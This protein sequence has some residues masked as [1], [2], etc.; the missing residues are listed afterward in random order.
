ME[1]FRYSEVCMW[2]EGK[3]L[4]KG[5]DFDILDVSTDSRSINRGSL[6]I[7]LK[8]DKFDGHNFI[9]DAV[10]KGA[11]SYITA[12]DKYFR[13]DFPSILVQDTLWAYQRIAQRYLEKISVPVVAITG[14][15]GKTTTKDMIH[16]LLSVKYNVVATEKNY[17]NEIGVP[18]T[19]LRLN[20]N[21]HV[22]VLELAMRGKG[23][24][25]ELSKIVR[26]DVVVITNIGES[27]YEL[28]GSYKAIAEAKCEIFHGAKDGGVS[29]LNADDKWFSFCVKKSCGTVYSY[30]IERKANI[31]LLNRKNRGFLG[32]DLD[33]RYKVADK[34]GEISFFLPLLGE[35]NI[36]NALASLGVGI[37]WGLTHD[38]IVEGFS[39]LSLTGMRMEVKESSGGWVV[40]ND[41]Y[42]ASPT[43]MKK[44][45]E[46]LRGLEVKGKRG[47]VLG[48][49]LELGD[50]ALHS[51][52]EI[53]KLVSK[54]GFD[55][56]VCTGNLGRE[57]FEEALKNGV[58]EAYFFD[59]KEDIVHFLKEILRKGD[60]I[61][62]KASRKMALEDVVEAVL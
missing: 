19:V 20:K 49:M 46:M 6:F 29:F 41:T 55:F 52:R 47:L 42:N 33:V 17:N 56:L 25:S 60:V 36:Y 61:L 28:L 40:I 27:H 11:S 5:D 39:H 16:S 48:D 51:H 32:M 10:K 12:N 22:L 50:L 4:Y 57:I 44:A 43:S 37:Y 35:H 14:S 62:V 9:E 38:E 34:E 7:P 45:I 24:I 13:R 53:G 26:P 58:G 23:Q 31:Y 8:G 1:P 21:T 30:G 54:G 3:S 18:K 2:V 15:N 59:K